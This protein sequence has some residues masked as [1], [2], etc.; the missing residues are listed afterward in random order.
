MKYLL[1]LTCFF[2]LS[3]SGQWNWKNVDT[4]FQPLPASVHVFRTDD[5]TDGKPNIAYYVSIDLTDKQR[6][7]TT[8]AGNGK[9]YTPTQYFEQEGKPLLVMNCTFF[10]FVHNSNL[11]T[12]VKDGRMAAYQVHSI[13]GRGKDTLT[14]RHVF[15]S[16]IGIDKKGRADIAWLYTDSSS[17]YP[18][19][20]Q[21]PVASFRDSVRQHTKKA[22]LAK[23]D[24]RK[25]KMRTAT[26]GGPVLLQDGQVHITNNEELKFTGKAIDDKH[27][28]T[29][30][31]YTK[32][33]QLIFLV[34]EGRFPN[35]AEGA[36]LTQDANM[37]QQLGCHEAMNLDGGGSSCLL[38]N[39]K[40]T[41][42]P[43]DREGQRAVP[44]VLIVR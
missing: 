13:A 22:M 24:F 4:A 34:I 33:N 18:Y 20:S 17:K 39:G 5:L 6:T 43:S 36:T 37:L 23:A 14:Y 7:V 35:R 25:W 28:R 2:S 15:G 32:N 12:V 1:L 30:I 9:R 19:A 26:G 44:A 8:Q 10:E 16:A 3:A 11:N 38:I 42:T 29:A 41:I 21:S 40:Q 31:G 27:P